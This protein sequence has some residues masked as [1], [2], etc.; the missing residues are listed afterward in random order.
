MLR[1]SGLVIL[2]AGIY[3][4]DAFGSGA[5]GGAC[6]SLTPNHGGNAPQMTEVPYVIDLMQFSDNNGSY[7][8]IPDQTYTR[9][10]LLYKSQ[11][12]TLYY[13]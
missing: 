6:D 1:L 10:K 11:R 5:P 4:T 3:A 13:C 2:L 8:Y 7:L 9:K 12:V